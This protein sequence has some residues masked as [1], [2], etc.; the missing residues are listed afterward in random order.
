MMLL[1]EIRLFGALL[2]IDLFLFCI[3]WEVMPVPMY[4]MVGIWGHGRKIHATSKFVLFATIGS[5]LMLVAIL[6]LIGAGRT[7]LGHLTFDLHDLYRIALSPTEARWL[8]A[9]FAIAFALKVPM[10]APC[11]GARGTGRTGMDRC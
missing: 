6:Y 9:G 11:P 10:S 1:L 2:A 4:L 5:L 3:F 7:Q 8:I